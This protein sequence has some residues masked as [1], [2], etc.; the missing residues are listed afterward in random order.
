MSLRAQSS[1]EIL[2][3]A[4]LK[5]SREILNLFQDLEF[6]KILDLPDYYFFITIY[7]ALTLCKFTIADPLITTTQES[8]MDLAPND[9]HIAFRFGTVL[10]QIRQKAA[11]AGTLTDQLDGVPDV[12][13]VTL[14]DHYA[15][16]V[17]M[18][19]FYPLNM[20]IPGLDQ[21]GL[22]LNGN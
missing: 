6:T 19:G 21:S 16:D 12:D 15:W 3:D 2:K 22:S 7:A 4:A 14:N 10:D 5:T 13:A 9:E 1:S 18:A 8:L 20:D 11:A 17:L